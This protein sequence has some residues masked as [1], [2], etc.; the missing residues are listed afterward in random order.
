MKIIFQLFSENKCT[1]W[2][3]EENTGKKERVCI[4]TMELDKTF[5]PKSTKITE[6]Q[7]CFYHFIKATV[8]FFV[9]FL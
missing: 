4:Y 7:V 1:S 2:N 6:T 3:I 5:G 8:I 9:F